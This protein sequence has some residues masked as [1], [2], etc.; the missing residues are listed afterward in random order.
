MVDFNKKRKGSMLLVVSIAALLMFILLNILSISLNG[1]KKT[2]MSAQRITDEYLV[3]S[4]IDVQGHLLNNYFDNSRV[5][6]YYREDEN[7]MYFF[8]SDE[9]FDATST[10]EFEEMCDEAVSYIKL[11]EKAEDRL[12]MLEINTY[13]NLPYDTSLAT[14]ATLCKNTEQLTVGKNAIAS[15]RIELKEIPFKTIIKYK[16][17]EVIVEFEITGIKMYTG[18]SND[19]IVGSSS[20]Y[21]LRYMEYD[22]SDMNIELIGL[23]EVK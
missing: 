10:G 13:I 21:T 19:L 18:Q 9:L 8:G 11:N 5:V 1:G 22:T 12:N 4:L 6:G 3:E 14:L 23:R 7:Y 2:V 20:E 16:T 17:K 15:Y